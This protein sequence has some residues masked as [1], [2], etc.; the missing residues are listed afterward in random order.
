MK[1]RFVEAELFHADMTKLIVIFAIFRTNLKKTITL[2]V[3]TSFYHNKRFY[4]Q[5]VP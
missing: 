4:K 2:K 3:C 1:I 5:Y